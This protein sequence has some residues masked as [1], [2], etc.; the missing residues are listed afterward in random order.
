MI[1]HV[2]EVVYCMP[3]MDFCSSR[4]ARGILPQS[5]HLGK[6]LHASDQHAFFKIH[7]ASFTSGKSADVLIK[8]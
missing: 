6:Q 8:L 7:A 5:T 3:E 4:T 1:K 2:K